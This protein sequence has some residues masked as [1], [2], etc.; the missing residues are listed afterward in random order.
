[1]YMVNL[2]TFSKILNEFCWNFIR[3]FIIICR[4]G[5][6]WRKI[7][8]VQCLLREIYVNMGFVH[9][10]LVLHVISFSLLEFFMWKVLKYDDRFEFYCLLPGSANTELHCKTFYLLLCLSFLSCRNIYLSFNQ[11]FYTKKMLPLS[12]VCK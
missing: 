9:V 8:I 1:M 4:C 11:Y 7:N 3:E 2:C 12:V 6:A 10:R 5:S